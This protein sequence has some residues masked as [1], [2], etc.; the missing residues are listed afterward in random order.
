MAEEIRTFR[1]IQDAIIER[2]KLENSESVRTSLKEKINT[3]YNRVCFEE[4]Y[5]WTAAEMSIMLK[6]RYTTGTVTVTEGSDDITGS[7]TSWDANIHFGWK[8]QIFGCNTPF[9][10]IRVGSTT[11]ITLDTPWTGDSDT[12][13]SY[14]LYKD[15]YGLFPDCQ[16]VRRVRISG[17][18]FRRQPVGCG[19]TEMDGY[20]SESPFRAGLPR[21][22]TTEGVAHYSEKTWDTFNIDQDFW[23]DS[24]DDEPRNPCLIVYPGIMVSDT[25]LIVRYTKSIQ[26]MDADADEPVIPYE[27]RS[28]LVWETLVDHFLQNRDIQ[29]KREWSYMATREKEKMAGEIETTSDEMI[30]YVDKRGYSRETGFA[31]TTEDS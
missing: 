7:A 13:L 26:P 28:V 31:I 29:I 22:Y 16:S 2:A 5:R 19:P 24:F 25:P 21:L 12:G 20:R 8:M 15:E 14:T 4:E 30:L 6:K 10:V 23:E 17:I 1:N 27:N 3:V 9:K 18:S 11:T